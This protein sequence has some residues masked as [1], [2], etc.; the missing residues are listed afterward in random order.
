MRT[1][2]ANMHKL[3]S[4]AVLACTVL[5]SSVSTSNA[6]PVSQQ[7]QWLVDFTVDDGVW[8]GWCGDGTF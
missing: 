3:L 5:I 2:G 1:L 8:S 7:E 4:A 6:V